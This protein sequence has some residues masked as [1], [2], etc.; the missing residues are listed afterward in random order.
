MT[1][2]LPSQDT[3]AATQTQGTSPPA[4]ED[5]KMA[6]PDQFTESLPS[7]DTS[8]A[9]EAQGTSPPVCEDQTMSAP[10]QI[11][12]PLLSQGTSAVAE[13]QGT[14]QAVTEDR[15]MAPP[16]SV[17]DVSALQKMIEPQGY[18]LQS[19]TEDQEMEVTDTVDAPLP[20]EDAGVAAEPQGS[21][22]Q[23]ATEEKERRE[24]AAGDSEDSGPSQNTSAAIET[25]ETST[26]LISKESVTTPLQPSPQSKARNIT[27]P[28]PSDHLGNLFSPVQEVRPLIP[29]A[30]ADNLVKGSPRSPILGE[31]SC[32]L[33]HV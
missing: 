27:P 7:Q 11:T 30:S 17:R 14:S 5:L 9:T 1:E 28:V 32:S 19:V 22:L 10:D 29:L 21:F 15:E 20:S 16:D 13:S 25:Q 6:A 8:A 4:C 12:Q 31:I 33:S 26:M 3:S 2:S 23:P 18:A 24:I